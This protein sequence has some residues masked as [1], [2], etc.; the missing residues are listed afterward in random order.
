MSSKELP[1][2]LQVA[3]LIWAF[4]TMQFVPGPAFLEALCARATR[5]LHQYSPQNISNTCW[6][7][8]TLGHTSKVCAA[9]NCAAVTH[10]MHILLT[11]WA[12]SSKL[13]VACTVLPHLLIVCP[14]DLTAAFRWCSAT[15]LV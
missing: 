8:A 6:A 15:W 13:R 7:L 12:L 1:V 10:Q 14:V 3:N 4:A 11:A 2:L 5:D 9:C